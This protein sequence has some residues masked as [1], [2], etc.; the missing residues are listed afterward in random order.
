MP[1]GRGGITSSTWWALGGG[2][3][4]LRPG[5]DKVRE[6]AVSPTCTARGR[7][8]LARRHPASPSASRTR[9]TGHHVR[10]TRRGRQPLCTSSSWRIS[11][12]SL[13]KGA[14]DGGG[15]EVDAFAPLGSKAEVAAAADEIICAVWQCHR[16]CALALPKRLMQ[17]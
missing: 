12:W 5:G 15:G 3:R 7:S 6:S 11:S 10:L 13:E 16:C 9:T 14:R 4:F 1:Y 8:N 2:G 17:W